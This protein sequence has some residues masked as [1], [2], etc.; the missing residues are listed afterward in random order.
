MIVIITNVL[1]HYFILETF[2]LIVNK[3]GVKKSILFNY[4]N[5]IF[6]IF[7]AAISTQKR[8]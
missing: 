4:F 6:T 1:L 7:Y 3:H 5:N 2:Y 8:R